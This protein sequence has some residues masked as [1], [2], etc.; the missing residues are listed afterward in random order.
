MLVLMDIA[1]LAFERMDIDRDN[2]DREINSKE[3]IAAAN[4]AGGVALPT[5]PQMP[6]VALIWRRQR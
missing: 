2:V 3:A 4:D 1:E 6:R 5:R